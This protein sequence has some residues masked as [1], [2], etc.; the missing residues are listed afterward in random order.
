M[1]RRTVEDMELRG[2]T[3]KSLM[4]IEVAGGGLFGSSES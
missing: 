1:I 4:M 2:P 3:R